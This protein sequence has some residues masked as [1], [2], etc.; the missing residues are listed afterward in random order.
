MKAKILEYDYIRNRAMIQFEPDFSKTWDKYRGK[1]V[2]VDIKLFKVKRSGAANRYM[3]VL[4]DKIAEE[5]HIT[6]T[7][8]Y[9]DAVKDVGGVSDVFSMIDAAVDRFCANWEAQGL[10]WQTERIPIGD[11]HT[12]VIAYYGS[13]TFDRGQM[14]RLIE[15]LIFTAEELG[16]DT[17]TPDKRL[18]WESLEESYGS[19]KDYSDR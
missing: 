1:D 17:D 12:D 6:T 3:W 14:T 18:W 13:S 9:R 8:V 7:E 16:I 19:T 11:G 15:N 4:V 5:M 2:N 10:G